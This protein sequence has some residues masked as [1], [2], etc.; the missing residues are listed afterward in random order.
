MRRPTPVPSYLKHHR[1]FY[2]PFLKDKCNFLSWKLSRFFIV[3][4][5]SSF[6]IC[7]GILGIWKGERESRQ[8]RCPNSIAL[9]LLLLRPHIH[10]NNN[11][12]FSTNPSFLCKAE[13][14]PGR[15][16][17]ADTTALL[18]PL[19]FGLFVYV[20]DSSGMEIANHN[21]KQGVLNSIMRNI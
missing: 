8:E 21:K 20:Y 12:F 5:S 18:P 2:P 7:V 17:G 15:T 1:H 16:G 3:S 6:H 19:H 10:H 9:L 4:S 13:R 11:P 14:D